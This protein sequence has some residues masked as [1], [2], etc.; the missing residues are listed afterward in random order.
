MAGVFGGNI[1]Q[2]ISGGVPGGLSGGDT[3]GSYPLQLGNIIFNS[4]EVPEKLP[5]G[6]VEQKLVTIDLIGGGR[7]L[8]ALGVQPVQVEWEGTFYGAGIFNRVQEIRSYVVGG[9]T[10]TLLWN[11]ESWVV[12]V[13]EF[14]PTYRHNWICDYKIVVEIMSGGALTSTTFPTVDSQVDALNSQIQDEINSIQQNADAQGFGPVSLAWTDY[15]V[16]L[17]LLYNSQTQQVGGSGIAGG[18]FTF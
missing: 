13:K 10:Q 16:A 17:G 9:Q 2:G 15:L 1:G 3:P 18:G 6:A 5:I 14:I 11:S 4:I 12:V 8:Q 7:V